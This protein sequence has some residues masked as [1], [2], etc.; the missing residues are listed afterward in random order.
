MSLRTAGF[1]LG[2]VLFL[3]GCGS[4]KPGGVGVRNPPPGP[5]RRLPTRSA[6]SIT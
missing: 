6:W 5:L 1:G 2:F 3:S 4:V